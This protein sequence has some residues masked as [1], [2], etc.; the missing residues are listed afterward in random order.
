MGIYYKDAAA[1]IWNKDTYQNQDSSKASHL[2]PSLSFSSP[3]LPPSFSSLSDTHT[4]SQHLYFSLLCPHL[5]PQLKS[6][7]YS[8]S[9][10]G[11]HPALLPL[12]QA[13]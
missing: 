7:G 4:H 9:F 11:F 8:A 1:W 5:V 3:S 10:P 13:A 2:S 6:Q 12:H